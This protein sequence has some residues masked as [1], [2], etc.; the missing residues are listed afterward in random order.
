M[1]NQ[2]NLKEDILQKIK[3]GKLKM[4]PKVFFVFKT[5]FLILLFLALMLSATYLVGFIVFML[6]VSGL[7]F[8]PCFGLMGI[9]ILFGTLPYLLIILCLAL[10]VFSE[11]FI[12]RFAFVYK[13]PMIYSFL[14]IILIVLAFGMVTAK[15][16]IHAGIFQK[17]SENNLPFIKPFY[18]QAIEMKS[19]NMHIGVISEINDLDFNIQTL[20]GQNYKV[21]PCKNGKGKTPKILSAGQRVVI[22]GPAKNNIIDCFSILKVADDGSLTPLYKMKGR[23]K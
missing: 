16:S 13:R 20:N 6:R 22:I 10:I 1:D 11:F 5:G 9:K 7:W 23:M 12:K 8:L 19:E 4:R 21:I 3:A 2:N 17:A 18:D 15:T 14:G